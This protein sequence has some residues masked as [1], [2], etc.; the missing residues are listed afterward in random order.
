MLLTWDQ[1]IRYFAGLRQPTAQTSLARTTVLLL[2]LKSDPALF[3]HLFQSA[4]ARASVW[5]DDVRVYP[6]LSTPPITDIVTD[7]RDRGIQRLAVELGEEMRVGMP[8]ADFLT[9]RDRL[10]DVEWVDGADLIWRQRI[11]KSPAE[12]EWMRRAGRATAQGFH[13]GVSPPQGRDD[14]AASGWRAPGRHA[15]GWR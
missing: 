4:D 8:A 3:V 9:I 14:R 7:I 1:N 2:P 11:R 10:A 15:A 6:E 5:F 13:L 12:L